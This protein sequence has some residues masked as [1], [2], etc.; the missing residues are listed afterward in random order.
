MSKPSNP[1]TVEIAPRQVIERKLLTAL[2]DKSKVAI[3]ATQEDLEDMIF[4]LENYNWNEDRKTRCQ[5]MADGLRQLLREA[6]LR[7]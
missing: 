5:K 7:F 6:F 3:L 2:D 1:I 4:A